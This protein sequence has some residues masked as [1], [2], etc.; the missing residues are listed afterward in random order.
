MGGG[1]RRL[2]ESTEGPPPEEAVGQMALGYWISQAIRTMAV[3]GLADHLAAG[4]RTVDELA[5]QSSAHAPSLDRLLRALCAL[6]L[7]ARDAEGRVRLTQLGELLRSDAPDSFKS[8]VLMITAPHIQRAW[9][10]LP[11]AV[12]T[13]EPAFARIHGIGFWEYLVA[14]PEEGA[15]FDAAMSG[16]AEERAEA[17]LAACDLSGVDTIVDVG[18][19]QGKLL[20]AVLA[21]VPGLCGVLADRSEVVAGAGE[22]LRTAEVADRCAVVGSDFFDSAPSGGDAYVLAQIIHD[23]P[24]QEAL[25][26]LSTCHQA[27][28]PGARLWVIEQ[29]IEPGEASVELTL[30]DL[31]MLM[32][33]GGQERTAEE[34]QGLLEAAGFG[35]IRVLPTDTDWSVVEAVRT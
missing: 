18:G 14:Q 2:M 3:L 20:A 15:L 35:E 30:L 13:G 34:Y 28:A 1:R 29:V 27:M 10:K 17:L 33:F 19:G 6:S 32:L 22:V 21:A 8:S 4:P 24:K 5:E 12:R 9:E 23:W 11:D 26:I 7:C 31:N 25:E 16:D